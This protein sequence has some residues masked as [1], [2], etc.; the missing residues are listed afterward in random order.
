VRHEIRRSTWV[1]YEGFTRLHIIPHLGRIPLAKLAPQHVQRFYAS[2]LDDGL[3]PATVAHLHAFLHRALGQAHRWGLVPQNVAAL[4]NP[5][6]IPKREMRTL[7]PREVRRF[8]EV[9]QGDR[10]EALYVLAMTTGMRLGELLALRWSDVELSTCRVSVRGTLTRGEQGLIVTEPKTGRGRVVLVASTAVAA[11]R[12]H[13]ATQSDERRRAGPLWAGLDF[14][15]TNE[16]GRPLDPSN[17]RLRSFRPALERAGLPRIR[18]HDLRHT[19]ATLML[20][21][22]IHP[23]VVS[24]MLGHSQIGIT[25]DLYSH[26]TPPM[27][28]VAV[29]AI[30]RVLRP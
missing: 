18:L 6:R 9:V 26:V 17:V 23:K 3:A 27:Q 20:G 12:Q 29:D 13:L 28:Q 14:V 22:G 25:L 4:V 16:L 15:F 21:E 24:E 5:P 1:S 19:A 10:L 30:E 11:L 8:L 2:R 7:N